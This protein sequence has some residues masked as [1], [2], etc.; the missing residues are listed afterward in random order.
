M[1]DRKQYNILKQELNE[2]QWRLFLATEALKMGYGGIS[3][4]V[5]L[6]GSTWKTVK[7]GID[8]LTKK[9]ALPKNRVRAKGGGRKA[10][11]AKDP[12]LED[13]LENVTYPKGDPESPLKWTT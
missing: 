12:T 1:S 4:V 6:S 5:E 9:R 8:E 13:D 7:R 3:R 2:R 11:T 10:L